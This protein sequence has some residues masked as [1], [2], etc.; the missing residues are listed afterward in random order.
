MSWTI[1]EGPSYCP[2]DE[3]EAIQMEEHAR[4]YADF[5]GMFPEGRPGAGTTMGWYAGFCDLQPECV[6]VDVGL[7]DGYLRFAKSLG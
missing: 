4:R 7:R 6:N 2:E 3:R 5:E 1:S